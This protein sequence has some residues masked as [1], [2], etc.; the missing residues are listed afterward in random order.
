MLTYEYISTL[1]DVLVSILCV[2][3][4]LLYIRKHVKTSACLYQTYVLNEC[5]LPCTCTS[6]RNTCHIHVVYCIVHLLYISRT[7]REQ[8]SSVKP[9]QKSTT[10]QYVFGYINHHQ[11]NNYMLVCFSD[12]IVTGTHD[13]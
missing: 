1:V 7:G 2:F 6:T 12:Y 3:I 9:H 13:M 8:D 11:P 5:C 10:K 4:F